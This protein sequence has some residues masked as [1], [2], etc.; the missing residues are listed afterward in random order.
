MFNKIKEWD[1]LHLFDLLV[2]NTTV[3]PVIEL[4]M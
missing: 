2:I 1:R 4:K 3:V